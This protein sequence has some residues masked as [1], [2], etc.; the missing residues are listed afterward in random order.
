MNRKVAATVLI[1]AALLLLAVLAIT[2]TDGGALAQ[3]GGGYDLTWN[4]MAGGGAAAPLTGDGFSMRSTLSQNAIGPATGGS[5][6]LGQGYW[7]G[8]PPEATPNPTPTATSTPA[9]TETPTLTPTGPTSTP[10]PTPTGPTP[11]PTEPPENAIYLPNVMRNY[12][13]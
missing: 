9:P 3:I 4:V 12:G 1:P 11:T 8:A 6:D 13:P 7:Y 2:W 5:F 10:T